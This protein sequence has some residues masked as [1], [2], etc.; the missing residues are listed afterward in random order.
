M[1][2][3]LQ[4]SASIDSTQINLSSQC[5]LAPVPTLVGDMQSD[6][7]AADALAKKPAKPPVPNKAT[8]KRQPVASP[9]KEGAANI[10]KKHKD[11]KSSRPRQPLETLVGTVP[12]KV[13]TSHP[14]HYLC[15]ST[16]TFSETA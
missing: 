9:E 4:I 3:Q 10:N 8:Q 11:G 7:A 2:T 5:S 15:F 13:S 6:K 16:T 12:T 14:Q 1:T